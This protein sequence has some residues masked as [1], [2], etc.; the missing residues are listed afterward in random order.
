MF[1]RSPG[2]RGSVPSGDFSATKTGGAEEGA[3]SR[4]REMAR[5]RPRIAHRRH[6][7]RHALHLQGR[8]RPGPPG[9][10]VGGGGISPLLQ[11]WA[12]F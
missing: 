8:R 5:I 3:V 2:G 7:H 11:H 4:A 9:G 12:W 10:D 1:F 6:L